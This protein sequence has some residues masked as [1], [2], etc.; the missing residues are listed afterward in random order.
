MEHASLPFTSAS[1]HLLL[2]AVVTL[3][4]KAYA[5]LPMRGRYPGGATL[6]GVLYRAAPW[7]QGFHFRRAVGD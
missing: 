6:E 7:R 3:S 2:T 4:R 1:L 5:Q